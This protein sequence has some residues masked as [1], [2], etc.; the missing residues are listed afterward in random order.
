[1]A[2]AG[3]LETSANP[4]VIRIVVQSTAVFVRHVMSMPAFRAARRGRGVRVTAA[5]H[6]GV[7][8]DKTRPSYPR[9]RLPTCSTTSGSSAP[10]WPASAAFYDTVL[11]PLG[12]SRLMDFGVAIG[13]GIPTEAR[14]LARRQSTPATASASRTSPSPPPTGPR[15]GR[16][17]TPPSAPAPRCCTSRVCGPSTTS[18]T[19]APSCA[20]PTATTSRPMSADRPRV[21]S[22]R[23]GAYPQVRRLPRDA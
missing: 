3:G 22:W 2:W 23:C 15:C 5:R 16:S 20:T 8:T 11:A 14:L 19:T 4:A 12:G 9:D 1:M 18:T 10:T 6:R 17:S 21:R 13:Y 7:M